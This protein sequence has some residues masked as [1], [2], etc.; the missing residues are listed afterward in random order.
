M[1]DGG[2][3][4]PP[5]DNRREQALD[6][7]LMP[8]GWPVAGRRFHERPSFQVDSRAEPCVRRGSPAGSPPAGR[9]AGVYVNR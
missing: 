9:Q 3:R 4:M 2:G 6:R 7:G 5:L 8:R 1:K